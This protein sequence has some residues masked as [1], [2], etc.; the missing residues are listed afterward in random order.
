[1]ADDVAPVPVIACNVE[2][3]TRV[4]P[5]AC[6]VIFS[7]AVVG[8]IATDITISNGVLSGTYTFCPVIILHSWICVC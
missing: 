6:T 1:M 4:T 5:W 8:F 2:G 7:E 3:R